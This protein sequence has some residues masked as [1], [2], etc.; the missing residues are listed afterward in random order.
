[1]AVNHVHALL[2]FLCGALMTEAEAEGAEATH[3]LLSVQLNH[4]SYE[5]M[6]S[7]FPS[8]DLTRP[9][10]TADQG[11]V[12]VDLYQSREEFAMLKNRFPAEFSA[13]TLV[14]GEGQLQK[15]IAAERARLSDRPRTNLISLYAPWN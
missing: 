4:S 13:A 2:L 11:A 8:V 12:E 14:A 15:T 7:E 5:W 3:S 1:M 9:R 6:L 10:L